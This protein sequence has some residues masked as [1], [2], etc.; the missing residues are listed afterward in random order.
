MHVYVCLGECEC[1]CVYYVRECV[2]VCVCTVCVQLCIIVCMQC[3]LVC[4]YTLLCH[5][6][7]SRHC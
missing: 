4:N 7:K 3:G 5:T 1:V 2:C 6:V